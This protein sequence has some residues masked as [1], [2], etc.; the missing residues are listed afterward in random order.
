MRSDADYLP[1]A[2]AKARSV[3]GKV[4]FFT[5]FIGLEGEFFVDTILE[6]RARSRETR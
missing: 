3:L 1:E 6:G 4:S 2:Q 5:T